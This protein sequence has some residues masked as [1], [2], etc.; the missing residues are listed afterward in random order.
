MHPAHIYID[1]KNRNANR[2]TD[3]K[4]L[5]VNCIHLYSQAV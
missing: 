1:N 2:E 4:E 3:R 5:Y